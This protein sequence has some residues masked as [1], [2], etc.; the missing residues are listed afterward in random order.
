MAQV[1]PPC[2][3]VRAIVPLTMTLGAAFPD[4]CTP[5]G[6]RE[7]IIRM[8]QTVIVA[9]A[10]AQRPHVGGHA[11]VFLQYLLGFRRL[12]WDVLFVDRVEPDMCVDD[13]GR[14]SSFSASANLRYLERVME[15]FGL[16]DCWTL[17][18]DGGREVAGVPRHEVVD[19]ARRSSLLLNVM[20]Y[21][22]D[23]EILAAA[24]LR[25]LLDIDPGFGQMWQDLGLHELFRD[26]DRYVTVGERIG[27]P[28]CAIPTCGIDWVTT[29][30]PVE[31]G[32]WPASPTAAGMRF[33]SVVTW[34]GAF[35]PIEYAGRTYG[36]RAHEFRRFLALPSLSSA[37]FEIAL[38]IDADADV[39]D[40][41]RLQ[42]HG[43]KL[44]DPLIVASDPWC[45]RDYVRASMAELMIAK[46]LYVDTRGGW[47]SDRSACYLAS[48][49]PVLAQDTG[50]E[51]LVPSGEGLVTF[52]TLEEAVAGAQQ[53]IEDYPRHSAAAREIA[54][55]HFA[56]EQVLPRLLSALGVA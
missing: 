13:R 50:L 23:E 19:R 16:G 17:L 22:E 10:L 43:W 20:A 9:G 36:L 51:G 1:A 41:D 4:R 31:L 45:Y 56:A 55:E 7:K 42:E 3:G 37:A 34:R 2:H 5:E 8:R 53:I 6:M 15:G 27:A 28:D 33:T 26:H 40:V 47:F 12:G 18:Y 24:P 44:V 11:W 14:P 21:L 54:V 30:P 25:V 49:K 48:G 32:E 35:G 39:A 29:K 46:N 52:S 38:N